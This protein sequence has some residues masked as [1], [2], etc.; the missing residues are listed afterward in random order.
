[1][2]HRKKAL[3]VSK[4]RVQRN[5]VDSHPTP[6]GGPPI[7]ASLN[8]LRVVSGAGISTLHIA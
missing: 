8:L 3:T 1:V 6:L 5:L 4:C 7:Q 2:A